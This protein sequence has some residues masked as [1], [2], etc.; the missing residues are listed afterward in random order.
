MLRQPD[1]RSG[2]GDSGLYSGHTD[3][4]GGAV[5]RTVVRIALAKQDLSAGSA[6][7]RGI[8]V[9]AMAVWMAMAGAAWWTRPWPSCSRSA[10]LLRLASEHSIANMYLPL[11][12]MIQAHDPA[13]CGQRH[14]GRHAGNLVPVIA[15][16]LLGAPYWSAGLPRHLPPQTSWQLI[17]AAPVAGRR[18]ARRGGVR[19]RSGRPGPVPQ[20]W[21]AETM[22]TTREWARAG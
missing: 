17:G 3:L 13:L 6:F 19:T 11:A 14:L 16:N 2:Y 22:C 8:N 10:P 5:A 12:M 21:Q 18:L 20:R 1:W 4:N 7:L 15:G 9:L